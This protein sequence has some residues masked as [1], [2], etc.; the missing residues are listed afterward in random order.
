MARHVQGVTS[1]KRKLRQLP[2][3]AENELRKAM[4]KS[5]NEIVALAKTLVPID[6]GELRESIGWTW[7]DDVTKGAIRLG[8]VKGGGASENEY[9]TIYAGN[10]D[11]FYA[12]WVEFGTAPHINGGMFPGTQHPGTSARPF[13][14]PSYRLLRKRAQRRNT[15]A[16]NKAIKIVAQSGE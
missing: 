8:S 12:R 14:Y 6:S 7:G 2:R 10:D 4:E 5:A 13:F 1:L 16:L 3:A 9:I 11:A 15:R